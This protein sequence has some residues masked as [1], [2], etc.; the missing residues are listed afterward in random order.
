MS[1]TENRNNAADG[2][3]RL[4]S[5]SVLFLDVD[6]VLNR[7]GKSPVKLE[8]DLLANLVRIVE[9]TDCRIVLSSTWRLMDRAMVELKFAFDDLGLILDGATPDLARVMENGIW[10]GKER[11]HEIQAWMDDHF[12]P[13]RFCILDDNTDMA[14]LLPKLIKTNSFDGLTDAITERV[15][16]SLN[17][18]VDARRDKT[19]NPSD[20]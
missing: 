19:P 2:G 16:S 1:D 7:C 17:A 18:N 6:G 3:L 12:T 5:C 9:E 20:G 4:T 14:H 8:A 11:G 13:E 15:I 10:A